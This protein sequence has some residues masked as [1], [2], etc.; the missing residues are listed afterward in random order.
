MFYKDIQKS[1]KF[2]E[3]LNKGNKFTENNLPNSLQSNRYIL[4]LKGKRYAHFVFKSSTK[5]SQQFRF[6]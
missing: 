3:T 1:M 6:P 4:C 5:A 2:K